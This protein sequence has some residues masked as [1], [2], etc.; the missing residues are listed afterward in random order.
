MVGI[1][2]K[3]LKPMGPH[4]A[5]ELPQELQEAGLEEPQALQVGQ[6][7][8]AEAQ[9][10]QVVQGRPQAGEDGVATPERVLAAIKEKKA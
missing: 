4:L 10:L 1:D 8:V 6:V 5:S 7:V 2:R 3:M 9:P